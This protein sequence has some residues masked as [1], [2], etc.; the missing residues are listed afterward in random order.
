M[1][2]LLFV[3]AAV[4]LVLLMGKILLASTGKLFVNY[5]L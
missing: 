1:F 5:K 4:K 3:T 2:L